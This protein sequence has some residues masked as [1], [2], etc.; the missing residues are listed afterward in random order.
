M[1]DL[2]QH[3]IKVILNHQ[4]PGG[5]Y[6]ASPTFPDY[7]YCWFRDGAYTAYAMDL[8]GRHQSA[9]C[10]HD[11][12]VWVV[13][14]RRT[15]VE[16]AIAKARRGEPLAGADYLHTRYTL[17]GREGDDAGWPNFQLDGLGTWLW[18]LAQHTR[19]AGFTA[20][21]S[22]YRDAVALVA[23][24]LATLWSHPCY[25]CWEEFEDWVHPYTLAAI[26]GGLQACI[27]LGVESAAWETVPAAIQAYVMAQGVH[28]G[29]LLK[30]VGN[31]A[32]DAS[33]IGVA[34]PHRLLAPADP[35]MRA[36]V[37]QIETDLRR[38]GGGL[39]RYVADT[40][41]GGGEWLLLTAWLGWYYAEVGEKERAREM[42]A[43]VE[44]QA[45]AGG[46]LPEQIPRTLTDP[47][48][49]GI[50]REQRGEIANPLLWSHA[51]YII[52][53]HHLLRLM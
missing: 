11:W 44:A 23:R 42:L 53:R 26:Y 38:E 3:S 30:S 32:V 14:Q 4:A 41:Y 39:H 51:K 8:V 48:Y 10:F 17:E 12:C 18:A 31:P 28:D 25:D 13:N 52:L 5:G 49:L 22:A 9:R 33:L 29:R 2:Y 40:Y 1:P 7:H 47:R 19:L 16:R 43:W 37:S 45:S 15:V 50:W 6:L 34:T 27:T 24:Y 35:L 36:T 21:P 20:L 46:D